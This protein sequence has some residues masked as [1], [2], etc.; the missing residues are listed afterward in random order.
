MNKPA[1]S[2][3]GT[4]CPSGAEGADCGER[5]SALGRQEP[6]PSVVIPTLLNDG[7]TALAVREDALAEHV[8][9]A[10]ALRGTLAL[11]DKEGANA[12]V[13]VEKGSGTEK[14]RS[15]AGP[16]IAVERCGHLPRGTPSMGANTAA[17]Q[18][19]TLQPIKRSIAAWSGM[20]AGPIGR[21]SPQALLRPSAQ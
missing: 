3:R 11:C 17:G 7:G 19:P 5:D 2:E 9:L 16:K 6:S 1:E 15:G 21:P 18:S 12:E 13:L 20:A 14:E 10:D 8:S 4:A